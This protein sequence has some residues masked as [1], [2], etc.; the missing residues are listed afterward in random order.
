MRSNV[1]RTENPLSKR[2][3]GIYTR[4]TRK[5]RRRFSNSDCI[6]RDR[7]AFTQRGSPCEDY[8]ALTL[9][10]SY[11]SQSESLEIP[12]SSLLFRA[13]A[14]ISKRSVTE[15]SRVAEHVLALATGLAKHVDI[16]VHVHPLHGDPRDAARRIRELLQVPPLEPIPSLIRSLERLGVWVLALPVLKDRDAFCMWIEVDGKPIPVIA[17]C[18]D[19]AGDRLRLSVAHELGHLLLHKNQLGRIRSDLEKAATKSPSRTVMCLNATGVRPSVPQCPS[20]PACSAGH[21]NA[22]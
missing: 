6:N 14:S 17:V 1:S 20:G 7:V 4:K 16:P 10:I 18:M 19:Q 12:P 13:R 22:S 15:A 9:P 3:Q 8:H 2:T 5:G 11:F 21:S